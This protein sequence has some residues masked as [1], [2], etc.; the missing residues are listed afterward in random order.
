MASARGA[1][2]RSPTPTPTLAGAPWLPCPPACGWPAAS[3]LPAP[4][5][6][7]GRPPAASHTRSTPIIII[8]TITSSSSTITINI[9]IKHQ[10][11]GQLHSGAWKGLLLAHSN[12]QQHQMQH[13]TRG[14]CAQRHPC[15]QV[16]PRF[17]ARIK[18]QIEGAC[19]K[20]QIKGTNQRR[21]LYWSHYHSAGPGASN[22]QPTSHPMTTAQGQG[23][24]INS[25]HPIP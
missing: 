20:A 2:S 15:A 18:A 23:L 25:P 9:I 4:H 8:I 13:S 12:L 3:R 11:Q 22:K 5:P 6:A 17:M 16:P 1:A 21:K 7:C 24:Q 14:G 10:Q 19:I